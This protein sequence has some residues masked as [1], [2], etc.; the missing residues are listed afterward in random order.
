MIFVYSLDFARTRLAN[1]AKSTRG[2]GGERQ[3]TGL[4][5]VY[6]KTVRT[7]GVRG[8]IEGLSRPCWGL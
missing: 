7:D 8:C 1:D 3:F 2:G 6:R 5:D 4:V